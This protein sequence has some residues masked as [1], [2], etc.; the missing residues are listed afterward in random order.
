VN[1]ATSTITVSMALTGTTASGIMTADEVVAL[2]NGDS[3][4]SGLVAAS[5]TTGT[6]TVA[7]AASAA[8]AGGI[9][10]VEAAG[11]TT[12]DN[13]SVATR[14]QAVVTIASVDAGL[15]EVLE[16]CRTDLNRRLQ[17]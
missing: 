15:E 9:T 13:L 6:A 10:E 16:Q 3:A 12:V 8:L 14:T 11:T 4:I 5:A 7:T 17:I 1:T 2:V